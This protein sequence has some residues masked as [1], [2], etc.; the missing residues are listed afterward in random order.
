MIGCLV[1]AGVPV[2]FAL[3]DRWA[4]TLLGLA[5]AYS[6]VLLA[7]GV[8]ALCRTR[9]ALMLARSIWWSALGVGALV[10]LFAAN[11]SDVAR[12]ALVI[13][14]ATSVSLLASGRHGLAHVAQPELAPAAYPRATMV[15]MIM[16]L[17]DAQALGWLAATMIYSATQHGD[18]LAKM[19]EVQAFAM[20][21]C[22]GVALCALWGLYRLRLWGLVLSA[23]TT[24]AIG[25]LSLTPLFGLRD[26]GP[27]PYA[28]AGSAAIQIALLAPL[29]VAIVRRRAPSPP[30][31]RAQRIAAATPAVVIVALA[32][33]SVITVAT[34]HPL[35]RF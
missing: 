5:A 14:L 23:V 8:L 10:A 22:C 26:A 28:F 6:A 1:A 32:A 12:P 13:V 18:D 31:P 9:G 7:A 27:I 17:A 29:F 16:A 19:L 24:V 4:G 35:I 30:S 25:A 20:L 15:S 2:G 33:L 11:A 34:S 3:E 21:V